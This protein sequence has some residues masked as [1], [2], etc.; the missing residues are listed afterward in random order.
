MMILSGAHAH[1]VHN[2]G[3]VADASKSY[4]QLKFGAKQGT[5][6]FEECVIV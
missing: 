6:R 3:R 5:A 4:K 1:W 2:L